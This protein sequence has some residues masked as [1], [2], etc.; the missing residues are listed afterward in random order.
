MR[1]AFPGYVFCRTFRLIFVRFL[2]FPVPRVIVGLFSR[3]PRVLLLVCAGVNEI[4][5]DRFKRSPNSSPQVLCARRFSSKTRGKP[6]AIVLTRSAPFHFAFI[7]LPFS[8]F[9]FP[10]PR[11]RLPIWA[12]LCLGSRRCVLAR[13]PSPYSVSFESV[14]CDSAPYWVE[15]AGKTIVSVEQLKTLRDRTYAMRSRVT[16]IS[17]PRVPLCSFISFLSFSRQPFA[18]S[19]CAPLHSFPCVPR[20]L[21][22][23]WRVRNAWLRRLRG[24]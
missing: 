2:A 12:S 18:P 24:A 4:E 19:H 1:V 14:L 10:F 7:P 20:P 22:W 15:N 11:L 21:A 6:T 5:G 17:F 16:F 8:A 3:S 9:R 23:P 13:R